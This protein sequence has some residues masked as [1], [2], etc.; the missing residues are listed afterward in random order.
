MSTSLQLREMTLPLGSLEAYVHWAN[1]I[2][3][4][5]PQEEYDLATA[6]QKDNDLEAARRLVLAH[7]RFVIRVARGYSGY[8]LAQA[9][10]IQEG[11]I[12]LMKA[13]KRFD[14][15]IGVR[16]VTFAVHWIKAEI[17]EYIVRNWRIVKIA[18]TKAQRKVFF[19]LR[20][21]KKRLGW[22]S[23]EEINA[24]AE[25]LGVKPEV[26]AEMETR[27]DAYSGDIAFDPSHSDEE[28]ESPMV[29]APVHYL[30]DKR[31]D[32]ADIVESRDW[33]DQGSH[34]LHEAL[35]SLD[36][37]SV[38]I[39]KQRWLV[40]K[41]ATLQDLAQKYRVSAERIRQLEQNAMKKL[42]AALANP[43]RIDGS[44]GH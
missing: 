24:V 39:L 10:L 29:F 5:E 12:G 27:M 19:N 35:L 7:L 30:E 26:V 41:K 4:L 8:G 25:D 34:G 11:N 14:P 3:M 28:D 42:K 15:T 16:L 13:V 18:T 6:L 33:L 31:Y 22:F 44:D 32:P 36:E 2:P 17:H 23:R 38:D 21:M 1:Q 43:A 40:E 9:D 20:R 37:R